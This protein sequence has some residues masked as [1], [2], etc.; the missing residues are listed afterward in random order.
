MR[1]RSQLFIGAVLC[2]LSTTAVAQ[3]YPNKP[4]RFV[5]GFAPGGGTDVM[6]RTIGVKLGEALGTQVVVE[7]RPGANGNLAAEQTAKAPADGYTLMIISVSHAISRS[8]FKNLRYDLLKDYAPLSSIATVPNVIVVGPSRPVSSLKEL[9]AQAKADPRR[10]TYGT[11]G[12]GSPEHMAAAMLSL[13]AGVEMVHIPYKGGALSALDVV[14]GHVD[15]GFNTMPVALP[16]IKG[17]KMKALAVTDAKRVSVLPDVP[18]VA[19]AGYPQYAMSTWYGVVVPTGTPSE[20]VSRLNGEIAKILA[21]P[22]VR[23]RL[24]GLGAEP[25]GGS[26]EQFGQLMQ[27]EVSKFARVI[28]DANVQTE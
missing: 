17:G 20:I 14:A 8:L 13:M 4:I 3:G 5:V 18:T 12:G 23:E 6:A 21:L 22:D 16:H 15:V 7:N 2:A 19:E 11:S 28:K 27:S 9:I 10:I 25:L 24:A 26:P 1:F